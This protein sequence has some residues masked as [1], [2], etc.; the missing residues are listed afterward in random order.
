MR[1][2]EQTSRAPRYPMD[3]ADHDHESADGRRR[4]VVVAAGAS[5][6]VLLAGA[7]HLVGILPPG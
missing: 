5:A 4:A 1:S 2:D 3:H 7:L 6:V